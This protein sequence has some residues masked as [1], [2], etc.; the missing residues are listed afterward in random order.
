MVD[1][2]NTKEKILIVWFLVAALIFSLV[3]FIFSGL[4]YTESNNVND[5]NADIKSVLQN[6]IKNYN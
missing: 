6:L 2:K 4:S 5:R 1:V 3:G